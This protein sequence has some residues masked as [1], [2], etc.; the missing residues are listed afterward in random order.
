MPLITA[1]DPHEKKSLLIV[2]PP[3]DSGRAIHVIEPIHLW[4]M[5]EPIYLRRQGPRV[6]AAL[7]PCEIDQ[8]Q[9][10][11]SCTTLDE[12]ARYE[13]KSLSP[14][15]S[16]LVHRQTIDLDER[17]DVRT[18]FVYG[19]TPAMI[20]ST[21]IDRVSAAPQ[22]PLNLVPSS[23]PKV[24]DDPFERIMKAARH[25]MISWLYPV[26]GVHHDAPLCW[27]LDL[28][29]AQRAVFNGQAH[30]QP[31]RIAALVQDYAVKY[32]MVDVPEP[33]TQEPVLARAK[34]LGVEEFL[35]DLPQLGASVSP[36]A[37]PWSL[38]QMQEHPLTSPDGKVWQVRDVLAPLTEH[39]GWSLLVERDDPY[40]PQAIVSFDEWWQAR[41]QDY[42]LARGPLMEQEQRMIRQ[43]HIEPNLDER[44]AVFFEWTR[45][46]LVR[47]TYKRQGRSWR[48]EQ[49]LSERHFKLMEPSP[50]QA[51]TPPPRQITD[52]LKRLLT[53][54]P[55]APSPAQAPR[56]P[57][58]SPLAPPPPV[59]KETVE[60]LQLD[61]EDA[62]AQ[63]QAKTARELLGARSAQDIA[64]IREKLRSTS[65]G[66]QASAAKTS[67]LRA[68][69]DPRH[70]ALAKLRKLASLQAPTRDPKTK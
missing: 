10:R 25:R 11:A 17:G 13:I 27:V 61:I 4:L 62:I 56:P 49:I 68:Q 7:L 53:K 65:K 33:D 23:Y 9:I 43:L 12:A 21:L 42:K 51:P 20:F 36:I 28:A 3:S 16:L 30:L 67:Q 24:L 41:S 46:G 57:I 44:T 58:P 8:A 1:F 60:P 47:T 37:Q 14:E 18:I 69:D 31:D 6:L 54:T 70:N 19:D 64:A 26:E 59:V 15:L 50:A 55:A 45:L 40:Q 39:M 22:W 63:T 2:Q 66:H 5:P 34:R 32:G 29:I 38:D 48:C 52:K 35:E